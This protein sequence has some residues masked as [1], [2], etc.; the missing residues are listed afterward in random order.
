MIRK[1][2][3]KEKNLRQSNNH[4]NQVSDEFNEFLLHEFVITLCQWA[5]GHAVQRL[6]ID[7]SPVVIPIPHC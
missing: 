3:G 4:V 7:N 6:K 1:E 2:K 5:E